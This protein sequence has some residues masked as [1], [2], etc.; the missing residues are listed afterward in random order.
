M[1]PKTALVRQFYGARARADS[2]RK[3]SVGTRPDMTFGRTLSQ[4]GPEGGW[5]V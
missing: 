1:H 5:Y 4:V 2:K 3:V